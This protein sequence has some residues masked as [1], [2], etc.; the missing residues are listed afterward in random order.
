MASPDLAGALRRELLELL[1]VAARIG[2]LSAVGAQ[3]LDDV[4]HDPDLTAAVHPCCWPG[5][6]WVL[7]SLRTPSDTSPPSEGSGS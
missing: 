1:A 5:R 2:E 7:A 6:R 4:A 3:A